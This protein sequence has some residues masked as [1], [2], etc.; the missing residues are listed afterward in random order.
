MHIHYWRVIFQYQPRRRCS[1]H[2]CQMAP[3][4][5]MEQMMRTVYINGLPRA[6]MSTIACV[7][8]GLMDCISLPA[9]AFGCLF[10]SCHFACRVASILCRARKKR[11]SS[12]SS[13]TSRGSRDTS[14]RSTNS[15]YVA[16]AILNIIM[17]ST[18]LLLF[19]LTSFL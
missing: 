18:R 16:R 14:A 9:F 12:A 11:T 1:V 6:C 5:T 10:V 7:S 15:S 3:K 19:E 4:A 8:C 17:N 2:D 13:A